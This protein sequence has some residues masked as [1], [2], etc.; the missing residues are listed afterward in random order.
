[1][2]MRNAMVI[3]TDGTMHG[4][5]LGETPEDEY[6]VLSGAVGGYIQQVPLGDSGLTLWCHEE[7]KLIGL[8][9]NEGATKVWVKYWGQTDVM[10]GDCVITGGTDWDSELTMGLTP[11]QV[12]EVGVIA[13][14]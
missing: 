14:G 10:V 3:K 13:R 8:P 11:A 12:L 9:Y 4:V 2:T 1:M 7:G 5:E 6:E